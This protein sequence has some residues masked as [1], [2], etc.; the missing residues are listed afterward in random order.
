RHRAGAVRAANAVER[1]RRRWRDD[2]G[3]VELCGFGDFGLAHPVRA[4]LALGAGRVA[5]HDVTKER[6][7]IER[8]VMTPRAL[9]AFIAALTLI[10]L[11]LAAAVPLAP[12]EAYYWVW[13]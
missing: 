6:P 11:G 5:R 3:G 8:V 13:S 12:D 1:C 2:R 9:A 4:K 10:R 7:C